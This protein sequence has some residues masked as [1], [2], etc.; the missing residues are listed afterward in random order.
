MMKIKKKIKNHDFSNKC[1]IKK[2]VIKIGSESADVV[3]TYFTIFTYVLLSRV[4]VILLSREYSHVIITKQN[5]LSGVGMIIKLSN[6][7]R[8]SSSCISISC[9]VKLDRDRKLPPMLSHLNSGCK[10]NVRSIITEVYLRKSCALVVNRN[11]L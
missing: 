6:A 2:K 4:T 3:L 5:Q 8:Q 9:T 10:V 7:T 11:T 1:S